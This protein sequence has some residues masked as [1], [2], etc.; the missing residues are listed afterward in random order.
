MQGSIK[1]KARAITRTYADGTERLINRSFEHNHDPK[2]ED[3]F[4]KAPKEVQTFK[5][6]YEDF[7]C[8]PSDDPIV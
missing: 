2:D 6:C 5:I 1:C 8:K 4:V 7:E 3:K